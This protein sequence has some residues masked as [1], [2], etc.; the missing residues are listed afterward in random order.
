MAGYTGAEY[1]VL[2]DPT[3]SVARG[4]G[5][6][7][8]LNDGVAAPATFILAPDGTI[9]WRDVASGIADRP[10]VDE[11]LQQLDEILA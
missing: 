4:Y 5:V 7:N 11:I 6:Y 3:E 2:A 1:P 8:L 9:L 10:T